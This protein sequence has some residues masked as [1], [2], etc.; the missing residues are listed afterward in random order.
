MTK[1]YLVRHC[2]AEGNKA[3]IF[4]GTT[5]CDISE[6]GAKQLEFLKE[7]FKDIHIDAAFSS[8]LIR[9]Y[10]TGLAAVEGK[11]LEIEKID[12]F[13]E[14]YGGI[15]EGVP[16]AQIFSEYSHLEFLWNNRPHEFAPMDGESM[17]QVYDRSRIAL[18]ELIRNPLYKDI[19]ILISSHGGVIR[20]LLC[21]VLFGNI[22]RLIDTPWSN[23]T[24][25]SLLICDE[26]GIRAEYANDDSHIPEEFLPIE[27]R[28]QAITHA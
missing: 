5:D 20:C 22:E 17:Q 27:N 21:Y 2:E 6:N 24:A 1:I 19:T 9:A 15:V 18:E 3:K 14:M 13:R 4:Q 23:N 26:N 25:V 10:K 7:R 11:D 28:I 16:F 8:P 12:A